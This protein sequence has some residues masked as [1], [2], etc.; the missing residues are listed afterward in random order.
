M[1]LAAAASSLAQGVGAQTFAHNK[2]EWSN[3]WI[4]DREDVF[5]NYATSTGNVAGDALFKVFPSEVLGR[6]ED[7]LVSGYQ[8]ALSI[9][10]AYTGS[11]PVDVEVPAVQ[12]Y[13][14]RFLTIGAET[15]E[16]PDLTQPIGP[17]FDPVPVSIVSDASWVV[18]VAFDPANQN[19][20]TRALL[21]V[22]AAHPADPRARGIAL[23]V[24]GRSGDRRAP[25]VPGVVLQS[26]FGERH[27]AP[28]RATYSGSI[29]GRTG[30][31]AMFG[32]TGMPS[33][34][35][36]LFVALRFHAPVLQLSGP[37]AG[38]VLNDPQGFET[39]LG[40]GAYATDLARR[41][42]PG[43]VRLSVQAEQ[44]DPAGSAPTHLA[45][46]FLVATGPT[47]PT[48]TLP[49]GGV[50]LRLD[51]AAL[52]LASLL[53]DAG[54]AGPLVRVPAASGAG[55]DTDQLGLFHSPPLTVAPSRALAGAALWIQALVVTNGLA[56]VASTN[57]VRL[58]L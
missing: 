25:Q 14:T 39:H 44:F 35:G 54:L 5:P 43:H 21:R 47:G 55:F 9:D 11:F 31:L 20:R 42:S 23:V 28:G 10:D 40:P 41:A 3:W 49:F 6:G 15:Y 8:V 58:V 12:L 17:R 36:E 52:P 51:P 19:P 16:V 38:G 29:D 30:A 13:H 24:F 22:P 18:E 37:S 56:P 48:S 7:H 27:L 34:T 33:A 50:P 2:L 26:S 4:T 57:V 53:I 32:T 45:L 1:A 46:P